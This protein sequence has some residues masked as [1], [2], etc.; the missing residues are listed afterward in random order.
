MDQKKNKKEPQV[1][2][3][4]AIEPALYYKAIYGKNGSY[5]QEDRFDKSIGLKWIGKYNFAI[6]SL[7]KWN[8]S[9]QKYNF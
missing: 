5:T 2:D 9:K 1:M 7:E 4:I 3:T 6:I 8:E